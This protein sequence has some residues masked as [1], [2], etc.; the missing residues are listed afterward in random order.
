MEQ[1]RRLMSLIF[2]QQLAPA[3][4]HVRLKQPQPEQTEVEAG[5]A[6]KLE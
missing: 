1:A 4:D 2:C 3:L 5:A 6:Y